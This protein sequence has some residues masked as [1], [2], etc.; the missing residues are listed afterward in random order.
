MMFFYEMQHFIRKSFLP[1]SCPCKIH[2][3]R[4]HRNISYFPFM[5]RFAHFLKHIK[6]KVMGKF[7]FFQH[8]K[9]SSRIY[10]SEIFVMI[11]HNRF[12]S[13]DLACERIDLRNKTYDKI[14]VF[15]I[16]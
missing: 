8:I 9:I 2:R 4:D 14:P 11:A 3:N 13:A 12:R 1:K 6:I 5:K 10:Y 7:C 16:L 15:N